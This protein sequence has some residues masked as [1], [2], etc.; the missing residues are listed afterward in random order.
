MKD[1]LHKTLTGII[2]EH[3]IAWRKAEGWS[4][5]TV[6]QVII[7]T[8][9]RV[10]AVSGIV[11]EPQ[12]KDVHEAREVNA[13]RIFRWLDDETKSSNLIHP[14]F[15]MSV[16]AALPIERRMACLSAIAVPLGA[17]VHHLDEADEAEPDINDV[18]QSQ[19][20]HS[21]TSLAYTLAI[22]QPT[23]ENIAAAELELAAEEKVK[24]RLRKKLAAARSRFASK[25]KDLINRAF[26]RKVSA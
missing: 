7:E 4:R 15:I 3:V 8:H 2:R 1:V 12:T 6:A 16:L 23:P 18:I 25:T 26:N 22:Q 21:K 11:F 17:G 10:N 20:A 9:D 24:G 14:N 19:I 13:Q 5:E